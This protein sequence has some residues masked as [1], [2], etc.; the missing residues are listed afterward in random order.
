MIKNLVLLLM[1]SL[2]Y[3]SAQAQTNN[4]IAIVV[5]AETQEPM[6]YV[7]VVLL[8]AADSTMVDGMV[9][10][11]DGEFDFESVELG[12]Y[13]IKISFI[14]FET[15]E[16]FV[17]ASPGETDLGFIP[18]IKSTILL[19]EVSVTGERSTL[20]TTLNK[21]IYNVGKD[22]SSESGSVSDILQNVPSVTVDVGGNVTL[23]GNSN[24]T[25]LINGR[26]SALLRRNAPL[27]L[28]QLSASTIDRIEVITNPSAKY[29]PEGSGGII[30]IIQRKDSEQGI[31]GQLIGNMG[32][33]K[34]YNAILILNYGDK[35]FNSFGSYS[36]RHSSGKNNF[37]DDRTEKNPGAENMIEFY[38]EIGNTV[39]DPI[40]HI[41]DL[42]VTY[43]FDN[44]NFV[45]LSGNYF[46]Q[47]SM[48]EGFSD[49]NEFTFQRQLQ[50]RM[51][52]HNQNDE[53]ESEGEI[54]A[55]FE[56]IFGNNEEHSLV[57]EGAFAS[58]YER[59]TL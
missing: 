15:V 28:Q 24:I 54:G 12:Q 35:Q 45:E 39:S 23:R 5:E 17:T 57:I 58:Y 48:H 34:R 27:A 14:G 59:E 2:A 46:L 40:A 44:Q 21:K 3:L 4:I 19:E 20:T 32:N 13:L 1:L 37:S 55:A 18:I 38:Q 41:F 25:F 26:P 36:L 43:Q 30:N 29:N 11:E 10:D 33:E 16:K 8:N 56:H 42:G 52:S 7:N 49:L 31:N 47:N 9:T 51:R 50:S 53:L 6:Q 22:I